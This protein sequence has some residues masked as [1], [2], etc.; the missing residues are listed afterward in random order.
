MISRI[1]H[2]RLIRWLT[3]TRRRKALS[4]LLVILVLLTSLRL[5]FFPV[6][7]VQ[8]ADI[9]IGFDEGYGAS[10]SDTNSTVTA[11]TITNAVWKTEDL[12]KF[13]KCLYFDGTGDYVSY[14][15]SASLDMAASDT[16]TVELWFRTPDITSGTR[17]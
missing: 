14:S 15:D 6:K 3:A 12:C 16:V 7:E 9:Y 5:F 1:R 11:G 2:I 4:V 8:A 13:G 17:T 10:A